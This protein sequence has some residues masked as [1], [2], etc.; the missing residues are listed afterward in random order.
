MRKIALLAVCFMAV[1]A[2]V[3]HADNARI[4]MVQSMTG[5][6]IGVTTG[7]TDGKGISVEGT[8]DGKPWVVAAIV[9][10]ETKISVKGRG[11]ASLSDIMQGDK[12]TLQWTRQENDLYANSV[13][14]H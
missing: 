14:V 4:G 8:L 1:C 9:S 12:V 5:T 7:D 11:N 10:P 13:T 6:V 3:V 2:A